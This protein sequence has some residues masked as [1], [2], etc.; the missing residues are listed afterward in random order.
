MV[1]LILGAMALQ[2]YSGMQQAEGIRRQAE[3]QQELSDMN[4][5]YA[6]IDAW[7]AEKF[8]HTQAAAYAKNIDQTVG[9]QRV[10][11]AAQ[12]VD[13]NFGTAKEVQ[14]EARLTGYLNTMEIQN[15]ARK[16]A[17]G[18]KIE[19]SNLRLGGTMHMIQSRMDEA[20][21][22]RTGI[23]NAATTGLSLYQRSGGYKSQAGTTDAEA[24]GSSYSTEGDGSYTS[25]NFKNPEVGSSWRR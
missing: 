15:Q 4:A 16:K 20:S 5:K 1:P 9:E 8:G 10:G 24:S 25:M 3:L 12:N 7:E 6:E 17:Y 21:A 18:L 19:A 11:Y 22:Q 13:V 2:A 23:I 14:N